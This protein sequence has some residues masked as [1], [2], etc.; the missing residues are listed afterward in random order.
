MATGQFITLEGGE[1]TGK[2][3][4][5][6]G[7]K[8]SLETRNISVIATREPG[9]TPLAELARELVL[10]PRQGEAWS[11]LS[12]ALMMNAARDDHLRK[13]IRPAL[14]DG[15]WVLCDRFSDSTRVYQALEG[16]DPAILRQL[17]TAVVADT[18]PNLTFMLDGDPEKFA[19]RRAGR[20]T[21]DVFE[22]KGLD[23]HRAVRKAF[24]DIAAEEP[25]RCVVLDAEM[26]AEDVLTAALAII[27]TRFGL[28]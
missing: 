21:E 12:Q 7:L 11:S 4:L 19:Q 27:E 14:Q 24:L 3:T 26:P 5:V 23:F 10:Y 9:G 18:I 20:G 25:G 2:S 22:R 17:E 15:Q 16:T 1:G 13:S 28:T 8:R 6:S